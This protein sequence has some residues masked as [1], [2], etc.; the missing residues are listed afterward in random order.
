MP[1]SSSAVDA[2]T[3]SAGR[4]DNRAPRGAQASPA[5]SRRAAPLPAAADPSMSNAHATVVIRATTTR[6]VPGFGCDHRWPTIT[7]AAS[8][9]RV[10]AWLRYSETSGAPR[11]TK[12]S[13]TAYASATGTRQRS[14][15]VRTRA[16][17]YRA[18]RATTRAPP[19]PSDAAAP[20]RFIHGAADVAGPVDRDS[21][22][23]TRV[24]KWS[25]VQS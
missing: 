5:R 25:S 21:R 4:R 8:R 7:P 19:T 11:D 18:A 24:A 17:A 13:G 14:R 15:V 2:I 9:T 10:S 16:A 1:T 22:E 12:S 23:T 3:A 6:L 20:G